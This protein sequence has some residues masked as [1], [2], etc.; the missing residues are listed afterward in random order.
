[1]MKNSNSA[2]KFSAD[3]V[4]VVDSCRAFS[5]PPYLVHPSLFFVDQ[6]YFK[7]PIPTS[8]RS[9]ILD[10]IDQQEKP[11]DINGSTSSTLASS[12]KKRKRSKKVR[13]TETAFDVDYHSSIKD[14]ITRC[15][16]E[17]IL[18]NIFPGPGISTVEAPAVRELDLISYLKL[19]N[20]A[21]QF[22]ENSSSYTIDIGL[23]N[24]HDNTY[25]PEFVEIYNN[26]IENSSESTKMLTIMGHTF[27]IP[28]G[29]SFL[30]SDLNGI[31]KLKSRNVAY[32][33][34]LI[35]PPWENA[36]ASRSGAYSTLDP[37]ELF[38]IP[39]RELMCSEFS[40]VAIWVTNRKKY[41]KFV[42]EKLFKDW[43]I[44]FVTEWFWLKVTTSGEL[45]MSIDSVHRKPY[46]ILIIGVKSLCEEK[47]S[48]V[49][50]LREKTIVSVPSKQHS[51]KPP[52]G[53]VLVPIV[54]DILNHD[55]ASPNSPQCL[56]LFARNLNMGWC[57]WGNEVIRF[58]DLQ[59]FHDAAEDKDEQEN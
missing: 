49:D 37:Y 14:F 40:L 47:L 1:M 27:L 7:A 26:I 52:L 55:A 10:S 39:M 29:S 44:K 58:Q 59:W 2:I 32:K 42:K 18:Q 4:V 46:E 33:L 43:G 34:I 15:H 57:S 35:D 36:S 12:R 9:I 19:S 45:V 28:A 25:C 6:P 56:E 3:D 48:K 24:D 38:K 21:E 50:G 8:N 41:R 54:S 51:R 31:A 22:V 13:Q 17:V 23:S 30:M 11:E 5:I 16:H 20:V 53:D